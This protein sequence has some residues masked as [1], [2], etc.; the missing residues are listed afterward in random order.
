MAVAALNE[1]RTIRQYADVAIPKEQ[2]ET[3]VKAALNSPTA[4]NAQELDL[5]VCTNKEIL[6]KIGAVRLGDEPK[7]FREL[8]EARKD[9]LGVKNVYT[10][11]APCVIFLCKNERQNPMF[12]SIDAGIISM[13]IMIAAQELGLSTMC[14]G[15]F[16]ACQKTIEEIV[17]LP[18][19]SLAMAVAIGKAREDATV[20]PKEIVAKAN[21]LE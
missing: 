12:N 7:G 21:Y 1:R 9:Q 16:L 20:G 2:I 10:C 4:C 19:D 17:G 6:D 8:F 13:S 11:D 15:S 3:I 18:A 14:L 5:Y